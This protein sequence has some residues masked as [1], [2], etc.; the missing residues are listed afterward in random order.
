MN[1]GCSCTCCCCHLWGGLLTCVCVC[2]VSVCMFRTSMLR[3]IQRWGKEE[4]GGV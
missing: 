3:S 4:E 2:A 1:D